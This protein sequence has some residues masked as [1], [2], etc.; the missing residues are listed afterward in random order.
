[1]PSRKK[2]KGTL[3]VSNGV[4]Q[5]DSISRE[6]LQKYKSRKKELLQ[7]GQYIEGILDQNR[8]ILSQAITLVESSL[9]EHQEIAAM[10]IEGCIPQSGNSLR[11]EYPVLGKVLSLRAWVKASLAGGISWQYLQL[12]RAVNAQEAVS[13]ATKQEWKNCRRI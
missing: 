3:H 5:P 4:S 1:M 13:W 8:T 11:M 6:A 2:A 7:P 12:I 9:P 10:I